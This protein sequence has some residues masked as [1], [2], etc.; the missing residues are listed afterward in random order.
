MEGANKAQLEEQAKTLVNVYKELVNSPNWAPNGEDPCKL[1]KMEVDNRVASKGVATI[2]YPLE[3]VIEFFNLPDST[4]RIQDMCCKYEVLAT[5][6]NYKIIYTQFKATWPVSNRDFVSVSTRQREGDTQFIVTQSCSYPYAEVQ[7]VVRGHLHIGGYMLEKIDENTTR[8]TY[9][10]D[11]DPK[12]SIPQMIKNTASSRQGS[13]ASKVEE[14]I[15][16]AGLWFSQIIINQNFKL[17]YLNSKAFI[18]YFNVIWEYN[19]TSLL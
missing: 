11:S 6:E 7:G 16:K 1:Y 5:E 3:K 8:I 13:V 12:G 14:A 17:S 10:S 4:P 9:L 2:N 18:G 15:K 19:C